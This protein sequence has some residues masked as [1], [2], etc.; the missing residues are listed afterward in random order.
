VGGSLATYLDP[1]DGLAWMAEIL[2]RSR[3]S[4]AETRARQA[5]A[6]A[7]RPQRWD[8]YFDQVLPFI[9]SL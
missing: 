8:S 6:A 2:A 7:F 1:L 5:A 9:E 4:A 3:E